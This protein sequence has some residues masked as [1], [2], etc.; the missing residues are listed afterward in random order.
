MIGAFNSARKLGLALGLALL[1][2][3][4]A[5]PG[6]ASK[7]AAD[8]S[9]QEQEQ[10]KYPPLVLPDNVSLIPDIAFG[11]GG[12]TV[13]LGD[14]FLPKAPASDGPV[15]AMVYIHGG[16]W[17]KGDRTLRHRCAAYLAERGIAGFS[18]EYRLSAAAKFPEQVFDCKAAVRWLRA[19]AG[20]LNI[21]P[22]RIGVCGGSAG[23]HLSALMALT[24]D[25]PELEGEGGNPG[26]STKIQAGALFYGVYDMELASKANM[27]GLVAA[28]LG[29]KISEIPDVYRFAS[30]IQHVGASSP[31][32]I[33]L[34]GDKD[35]EVISDGSKRLVD[36]LRAAGVKTELVVEEGRGHS[37]DLKE[38]DLDKVMKPIVRFLREQFGLNA[39]VEAKTGRKQ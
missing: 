33:V 20:R 7:P 21:D 9:A 5:F 4:Q 31:P 18:I 12:E 19:N 35:G 36:A 24:G 26:F 29:G 10:S 2:A 27:K 16:G 23:G 14:L 39:A 6:A 32:C 30:P 25:M 28:F 13:L 15:P 34:Y 11:K 22:D 38:P 17:A 8:G 37:Y 3:S 1:A